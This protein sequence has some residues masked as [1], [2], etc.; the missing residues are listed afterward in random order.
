MGQS[1]RRKKV[2]DSSE[3]LRT[4]KAAWDEAERLGLGLTFDS[5]GPKNMLELIA[6]YRREELTEDDNPDGLAFSTKDCN[7]NYLRN[8]IGP[9]WDDY[10]LRDVKAVDVEKWLRSLTLAPGSR[11]KIRDVM[12][13]LFEHAIRYEWTDRNPI[14][15]VRQGSKRQAVPELVSVTDLSRLIFEVLELRERVMVF[16]D[17]STGLRRGELGGLK[18]EDVDFERGQLQSKRSIVR[19]HIGPTKTE[20]SKE[21][22]PLD[23]YVLADL[24]AWRAETPYAEDSDY[25][26]ASPKMNGAQPYWLESIIKRHIKLAAAA[27]GIRLKGWHTLRHT[28]STLLRANGSDPKVVQE[29]LRHA[30]FKV[31]MDGYTQALSPEKME[32]H[33]GVVRLV[34]PRQVPPVTGLV[35]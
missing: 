12:H 10:P 22:I 19:Q 9:R 31:T 27:K 14:T 15:S 30:S 21:P 33:S 8:W 17:F 20:A 32:A 23:E 11:K 29:L 16:L 25:V 28:Y 18:W 2:L 26:F 6:H 5:F 24:R 35:H 7:R 1:H 3:R 34:V 4:E 13:V